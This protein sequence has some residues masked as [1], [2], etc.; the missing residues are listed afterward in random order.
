MNFYENKF[1][2]LI[3]LP[4]HQIIQPNDCNLE[5][6]RPTD[7]EWREFI[8]NSNE[9]LCYTELTNVNP[10]VSNLD[11]YESELDQFLIFDY[12][13]SLSMTTFDNLPDQTLMCTDSC[14]QFLE[15]S[16]AILR[17]N[18]LKFH[19]NESNR[20]EDEP[21]VESSEVEKVTFKCTVDSC[22]KTYSKPAHLRAH[23]RRHLGLKPY[24]CNFP[25][26]SWRFS[27]SDELGEI[28]FSSTFTMSHS[29]AIHSLLIQ[30]NLSFSSSFQLVIK[31]LIQV[32]SSE[33]IPSFQ[34]WNSSH[35]KISNLPQESNLIV[36]STA[37]RHSREAITWKSTS[38]FTKRSWRMASW[39]SSGMRF[40]SRSQAG[41]RKFTSKRESAA[42]SLTSSCC[43]SNVFSWHNQIK[44]SQNSKHKLYFL[45]SSHT[46]YSHF[47]S[48]FH[49]LISS[50]EHSN[51]FSSRIKRLRSLRDERWCCFPSPHPEIYLHKNSL[52]ETHNKTQH[53]F[54]QKRTGERAHDN[55]R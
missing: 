14:S 51:L 40:R 11:T 54:T 22:N 37:Q 31:D 3:V 25:N 38:K 50:K 10:H 30:I 34:H 43:C 47:T 42:F 39:S 28:R 35:L 4:P 52:E 20:S 16:S 55:L 6:L 8:A 7:D 41:R 9:E 26:C 45:H 29:D 5:G 32:I 49:L 19:Q 24:L 12:D 46:P 2:D 33:K 27:R 1:D 15:E 21:P 17:E 44:I 36:A 13:E 53:E 48:S 18:S 23:L